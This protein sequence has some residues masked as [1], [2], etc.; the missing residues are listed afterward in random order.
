MPT[1][2]RQPEFFF[3][4]VVLHLGPRAPN[5]PGLSPALPL[6]NRAIFGSRSVRKS[7]TGSEIF[8]SPCGLRRRRTTT[9]GEENSASSCLCSLPIGLFTPDREI[10]SRGSPFFCQ[11]TMLS[12]RAA[13]CEAGSIGNRRQKLRCGKEGRRMKRATV[14]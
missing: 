13:R 3:W 7:M 8:I 9:R 1:R 6:R 10:S 14:T 4:S 11:L 2:M 12:L 5:Y